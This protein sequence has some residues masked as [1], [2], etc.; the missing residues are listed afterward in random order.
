M[1]CWPWASCACPAGIPRGRRALVV[2][3]GLAL[4][5][6]GIVVIGDETPYPGMAALIPVLGTVLVI[7]GGMA[8]P[9][10]PGRLLANPVAG[11]LG[12]ISYSL[13]LWHWP[14]LI[15][16]PIAVGIDTLEFRLVLA[17]VA[18]LLAMLST[19]LV[20]RPFRRGLLL[21]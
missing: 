13:Y 12:R 21:R 4:V 17:G 16:V 19:E 1:R 14:L 5:I 18:V 11:Y 15:L 20:E 8:G 10:L 3:V 9:T 6:V 2:A 7:L